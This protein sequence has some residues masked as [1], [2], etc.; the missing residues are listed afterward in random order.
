MSEL[1]PLIYILYT[2]IYV[3]S[4]ISVTEQPCKT[5]N[6]YNFLSIKM[7]QWPCKDEELSGGRA[8]ILLNFMV[9]QIIADHKYYSKSELFF[10]H[11]HRR[12]NLWICMDI[13]N[14]DCW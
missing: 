3:A 5:S 1:N 13:V 10:M 12:L 8:S 9:N 2:T 6:S 14:I 7:H 11:I 4:Y